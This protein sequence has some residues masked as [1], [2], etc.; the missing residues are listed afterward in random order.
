LAEPVTIRRRPASI[1]NFRGYMFRCPTIE[2]SIMA[3]ELGSFASHLSKRLLVRELQA[4]RFPVPIAIIS[5]IRVA[6]TQFLKRTQKT[7]RQHA[8]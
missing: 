5:Q 2:Q 6:S 8:R 3:L 7:Y 1:I 4:D